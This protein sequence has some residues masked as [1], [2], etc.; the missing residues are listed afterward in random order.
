MA[1]S[2]DR[3][4][5]ELRNIVGPENVSTSE[6]DRVIYMLQGTAYDRLPY[7][8]EIV[9]IPENT[10]QISR[11]LSYASKKRIPVTAKGGVGMGVSVAR[12]GGILLDMCRMDKILRIDEDRQIVIA[13]GGASVYNIHYELRKR[14]LL[15]PN[16]G[17]YESAANI[18]AAFI[19]MGMG[20]G[21]TKYGLI[22]DMAI[23]LEAVLPSGEVLRFGALLN[24]NMPAGV[25]QKNVLGP[26]LMG[27]FSHSQGALGI[28]TR[29]ALRVIR[30]NLE[31]FGR[32][33]Y[34]WPHDRIEDYAKAT[35]DQ[36]KNET[37]DI[38]F[39]D[40]WTFLPFIES[41]E[42]SEIPEDAWLFNSIIIEARS[43]EELKAKEKQ[44]RDTL[45]KRGK[46]R[47]IPEI[48]EKFMGDHYY[49]VCG[50]NGWCAETNKRGFGPY[51]VLS[52]YYPMDFFPQMY[53]VDEKA[54]KE[55]GLWERKH[56]PTQDAYIT[57]EIA[58][59]SEWFVHYNPHNPEDMKKLALWR[60]KVVPVITQSGV[61]VR[62]P[63]PP[64]YPIYFWDRLGQ[65]YELIKK[66]KKM[67]DP[68]NVLSPGAIY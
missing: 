29:I 46:G 51:T 21:T 24:E 41:G 63:I 23:G 30:G 7:R 11:I 5:D 4:A 9:V 34:A 22:P 49:S 26:D 58:I 45:E 65:T 33:C 31:D 6:L 40:R 52:M 47:E 38:H 44:M 27:L 2:V 1:E 19:N 13:E 42:L 39:N 64:L 68:E 59:K 66:I 61:V 32:Y 62:Y 60:S 67:I 57:R 48:A 50:R 3:I 35:I 8:P 55:A 17:S 18:G 10:Y 56:L 16:Y 54:K 25:F 15:L 43:D 28:I 36:I 20:Y 14:G 37:Y 53:M 12:E